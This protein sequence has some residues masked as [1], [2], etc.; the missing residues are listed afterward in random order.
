M[1]RAGEA[2]EM[3]GAAVVSLLH[4]IILLSLL[5]KLI[6]L[7][8]LA[9]DKSL[10][11]IL[12]RYPFCRRSTLVKQCRMCASVLP[13]PLWTSKSQV[14]PRAFFAVPPNPPERVS[15]KVLLFSFFFGGK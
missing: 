7:F 9:V 15:P 2:S 8:Y 12:V 14:L 11:R 13:S 10:T 6:F 4:F 5:N 1:P 3:I